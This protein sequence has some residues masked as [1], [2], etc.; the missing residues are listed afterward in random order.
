MNFVLKSNIV[1]KIDKNNQGLEG[2]INE[3]IVYIF[4]IVGKYLGMHR[5]ERHSE[6]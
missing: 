2:I 4:C 6:G 5:S 3:E 1:G